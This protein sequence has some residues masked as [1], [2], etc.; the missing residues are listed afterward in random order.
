MSSAYQAKTRVLRTR[1]TCKIELAVS[2][3]L[4]AFESTLDFHGKFCEPFWFDCLSLEAP[5]DI[6][7]ALTDASLDVSRLT[8]LAAFL[9]NTAMQIL[10][11]VLL[12]LSGCAV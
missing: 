2:V 7:C 6:H 1:R 4:K 11:R 8:D 3:E 12:M 10:P 5:G 9:G